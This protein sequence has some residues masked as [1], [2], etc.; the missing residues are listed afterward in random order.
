MNPEEADAIRRAM[1][2]RPRP[3]VGHEGV[4]SIVRLRDEGGVLVLK[5]AIWSQILVILGLTP[6]GPGMTA[7]AVIHRDRLARENRLALLVFAFFGLV[8]WG[9]IFRFG[10]RLL[11]NRRLEF[12]RADRSV[13]V[14]TGGSLPSRTIERAQIKGLEV[15][16]SS[17]LTGHGRPIDNF[18]LRLAL[19]GE[20]L[21]LF[22]TSSR[23]EMDR[24][25]AAVR[26]AILPG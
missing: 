24:I 18:T 9:S 26:G 6:F 20:P 15:V 5:E 11:A 4:G 14:F 1:R 3:F 21:D 25:E 10:Y 17:Y 22:S 23:P 16:K 8:A 7:M 2:D 13:R 19:E 12:Y